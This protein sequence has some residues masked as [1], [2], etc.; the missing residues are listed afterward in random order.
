MP[1]KR[2]RP[3]KKLF[4]RRAAGGGRFPFGILAVLGILTLLALIRPSRLMLDINPSNVRLPTATPRPTPLPAPTDVHGGHIVFT[5][6]R[7]EIEPDL[8][9]LTGRHRFPAIDRRSCQ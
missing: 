9:D 3:S 7:Q 2:P 6:T 5:C 4:G 1:E 8:H